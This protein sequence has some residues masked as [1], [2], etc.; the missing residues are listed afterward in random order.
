[1]LTI[2]APHSS[3]E[4]RHSSTESFSL[5]VWEYSRMRPQP[6]QVRLHACSGSSISTSGKR[7]FIIGWRCGTVATALNPDGRIRNGLAALADGL[8]SFCHSARGISLFL[9]I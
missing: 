7:F 2:G 5:M 4:A 3:T 9:K 8:T 6:V 1:M